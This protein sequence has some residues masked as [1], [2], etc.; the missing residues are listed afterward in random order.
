[1]IGRFLKVIRGQISS[2]VRPGLDVAPKRKQ[3]AY[4]WGK[5]GLL[6]ITS[7]KAY[8]TTPAVCSCTGSMTTP[9]S[10]TFVISKTASTC[11]QARKSDVSANTRPGHILQYSWSMLEISESRISTVSQ[12]RRKLHVGQAVGSAQGIV[13]A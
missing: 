3:M 10:T 11:A 6:H 1:M 13:Q 4:R 12:I 8:L 7:P 9:P 2:L 5:H